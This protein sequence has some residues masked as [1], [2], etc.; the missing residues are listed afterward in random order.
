MTYVGAGADG[1]IGEVVFSLEGFTVGCGYFIEPMLLTVFDGEPFSVTLTRLLSA[2]G[3][4]YRYTG[5]LDSGF[6]LASIKGLDLDGN[7]I[8]DGLAERLEVFSYTLQKDD[9]GRYSLGEFDYT[10]GSGW[11][12]SVNG[13]FPNYGFADYFPQDG[14]VVRVCFTLALGRDVGGGDSTGGSGSDFAEFADYAR[15]NKLLALIRENEFYGSG[16]EAYAKA[17]EE[18]SVWDASQE[19]VDR[20]YNELIAAYGLNLS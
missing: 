1:E 14:D 8:A 11:M 18:I 15:V 3:L 9:D 5:E 7:R 16:E 6:Y 10:S 19:L 4:E 17:V 12:Y 13:S 2:Y 20:V